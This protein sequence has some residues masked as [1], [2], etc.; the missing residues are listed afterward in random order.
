[1]STQTGRSEKRTQLAVAVE[2]YTLR[3]PGSAQRCTTEN[4]SP[5]GVRIV[6]DQAS[7]LPYDRVLVI[8][9]GGGLQSEG[10][11]VYCQP[12][13]GGRFG[14]G[15]TFRESMRT[16]LPKATEWVARSARVPERIRD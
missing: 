12:L 15:L 10:S 1:M 6:T 2:V 5:H 16:E 13:P 9:P 3:E 11:V 14:V 7:F 4:V 8:S